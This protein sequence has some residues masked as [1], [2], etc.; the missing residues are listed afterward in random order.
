[1]YFTVPAMVTIG[2]KIWIRLNITCIPVTVFAP[3]VSWFLMS[4][5]VRQMGYVIWPV[6]TG[7]TQFSSW[8]LRCLRLPLKCKIV[9]SVWRPECWELFPPRIAPPSK[10]LNVSGSE[11]NCSFPV[12]EKM[13]RTCRLPVSK[14]SSL[15]KTVRGTASI[16]NARRLASRPLPSLCFF[17]TP[18]AKFIPLLF[19]TRKS[20]PNTHTPKLARYLDFIC[21]YFLHT[22]SY[23]FP[24]PSSHT[25]P[26]SRVE[27]VC[28]GAGSSSPSLETRAPIGSIFS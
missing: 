6:V 10:D 7:Y 27:C 16:R 2:L 17:P 28:H 14:T 3:A 24:A 22:S 11:Q 18:E 9:G 19:P 4:V 23:T 26:L 5:P 20:S 21:G 25:L 15:R 1:M 8:L 12:P 13:T